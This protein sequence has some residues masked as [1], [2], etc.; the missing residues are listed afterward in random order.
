MPWVGGGRG[1]PVLLM[2]PPLIKTSFR[3]CQLK[4]PRCAAA[5][6][7]RCARSS[8]EVSF[9]TRRGTWAGGCA[10]KAPKAVNFPRSQ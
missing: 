9:F 3:R 4:P 1:Q 5:P 2:T 10:P 6:L 7:R 8:M